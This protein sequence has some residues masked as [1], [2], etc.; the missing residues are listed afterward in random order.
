MNIMDLD[1]VDAYD[2]LMYHPFFEEWFGG[3]K[4]YNF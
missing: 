2:K 1:L 3:S 4:F